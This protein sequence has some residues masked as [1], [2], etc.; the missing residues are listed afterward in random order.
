MMTIGAQILEFS[1]LALPERQWDA[2]VRERRCRIDLYIF[3]PA[4]AQSL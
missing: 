3:L 2:P 1:R 4:I